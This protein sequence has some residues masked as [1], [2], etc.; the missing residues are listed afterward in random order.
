L[1]LNISFFILAVTTFNEQDISVAIKQLVSAESLASAQIGAFKSQSGSS[2]GKFISNLNYFGNNNKNQQF[3]SNG[4]LRSTVIK[5]ESL[6]L[7][8]LIQLLQESI[9]SYVKAGLNLRRGKL[10]YFLFIYF[11]IFIEIILLG[12]KSYEIVWNEIN[13]PGFNVPVDYHTKGGVEFG[14][15]FFL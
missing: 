11:S 7:I 10:S 14:S 6:L 4:Q 13:K 1:F 5:A 2:F 12:Y 15:V 3:M 8:A 9:I